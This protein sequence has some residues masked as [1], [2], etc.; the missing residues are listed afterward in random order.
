[1]AEGLDQIREIRSTGFIRLALDDAG[2]RVLGSIGGLPQYDGHVWALHP[3]VA[4]YEAQVMAR[5]GL[6]II[7]GSDDEDAMTSLASADHYYNLPEKFANFQNFKQ[8]P[9]EFYQEC[10]YQIISVV[11]D[12]NGRGK[13]DLVLGKCVGP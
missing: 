2:Q 8:H 13:P 3:L 4:E 5:G 11:P 10:G 12:A 7:L 6:T 1:M 9:Y